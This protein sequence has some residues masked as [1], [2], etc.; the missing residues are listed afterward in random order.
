LK[1]GALKGH[2]A[3]L[4][5]EW[6]WERAARYAGKNQPN[7]HLYPGGREEDE[8]IHRVANIDG[9]GI[10]APSVGGCFAPSPLGICDLHGNLWE[11]QDN[12]YSQQ[13]LHLG[14]DRLPRISDK[15]ADKL[16]GKD[17]LK[18]DEAWDKGD[19]PALRGG[20]WGYSAD[21]VRASIRS[22]VLPDDGNYLV[23]F[24]VVLSL[25]KLPS[26]T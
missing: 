2:E 20:S 6:Q 11:W 1:Q 14:C 13:A 22:W 10:D 9:S 8:D 12:L 7:D 16:P 5:T 18:S 25:A 15:V 21:F 24:R 4:P 23:G 26:E 3:C 19:L 17:W